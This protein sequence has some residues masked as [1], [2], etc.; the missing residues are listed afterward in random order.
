MWT[1]C[2]LFWPLTREH[3]TTNETDDH[4]VIIISATI[5]ERLFYC[6]VCS[7]RSLQT[8]LF[9]VELILCISEHFAL[10]Q[11]A[12]SLARAQ[13]RKQIACARQPIVWLFAASFHLS[14]QSVFLSFLYFIYSLEYRTASSLAIFAFFVS[15]IFISSFHLA[16]LF[17]L[18]VLIW[19]HRVSLVR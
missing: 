7:P 5:R 13:K 14:P 1:N 8:I 2:I 17:L 10:I 9:D 11:C 16:R 12:M 18:L 6:L 19:F 4:C 15:T 3:W